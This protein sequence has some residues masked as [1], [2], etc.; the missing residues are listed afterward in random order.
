MFSVLKIAEADRALLP[1]E[2]R[3]LPV[4]AV[5]ETGEM[6]GYCAFSM[7]DNSVSICGLWARES[8]LADV[9]LRTVLSN[10]QEIVDK[11]E[12]SPDFKAWDMLPYIKP[13]AGG[14][15]EPFLRC[16]G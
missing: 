9:A 7:Q 12:F 4:Y 14:D 16:C 11:F 8:A 13:G 1:N 10:C 2:L 5:Y 6:T 3:S 15:I